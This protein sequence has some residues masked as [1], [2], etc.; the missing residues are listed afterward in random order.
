MKIV[1]TESQYNKINSYNN[2]KINF[3]INEINGEKV[4]PLSEG[5]LNTLADIAGIFDPTGI[6]NIGNAI[7]Y[8]YQG[9]NTFALLTLVSV[10]PGISWATKPFVLGSKVVSMVSEIPILG[11]LIK[12]F[13]KWS[14][15]TLDFLDKLLISKIPIVKNFA[16]G[17]RSFIEGL[18]KDAG[19]NLTE[20][21]HSLNEGIDFDVIYNDYSPI[22]FKTVC[23][24]YADG[25]YDKAQD[26]CQNGFVKVFNNLDK[27]SGDDDK[28]GG[29]V[30]RVVTNSILDELRKE[31]KT[32][33]VS[34]FDFER[35]D[36]GDDDEYNE[37]EYT[38]DDIKSAMETLSPKYKR[39]FELHFFEGLR[40]D[41]IADELGINIGTSKSNLHKAKSNVMNYLKNKKGSN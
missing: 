12:T 4:E 8:W 32:R 20:S 38:L 22:I 36:I 9:K 40:H 21:I 35:Y 3:L 17:M 18:K 24:R 11:W 39:V 28:V 26:Y 1:I 14:G 10:V 25:D 23:L 19:I 5:W 31:K 6:V 41:E 15:K 16:G 29:W 27:F 13:L 30:K 7:S 33:T 2:E 37:G 34:D